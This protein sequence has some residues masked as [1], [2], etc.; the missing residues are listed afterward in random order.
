MRVARAVLVVAVI[1]GGLFVAAD[2]ITLHVA[3]AKAAER[4]QATQGLSARPKVSIE[5]FPFL[6]QAARGKLDDVKVTAN[7]I[8]AGSGDQSV[9]IDSFHADLHG[10]R[11]S[12]GYSRAVADSADGLAFITYTDL[13]RAAPD[14]VTV[15]YAGATQ[16]GRTLVKLSAAVP[17]VGSHVSVLSQVTV[18][19]ADAIGLHAQ[20]LPQAFTALGLD[21][22]IRQH[23]DFTAQLTHLPAGISLTSLTATPDGISVAAGGKNVVLAG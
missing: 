2:R 1:L 23:I 13:T 4:A 10:V 5:G 22:L 12:D 20:S 6:T 17:G 3:E 18:R 16:D 8:T 9:R 11:L 14:G 21:G 7:D 19:G 15:S